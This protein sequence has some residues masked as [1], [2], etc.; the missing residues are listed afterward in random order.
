[1]SALVAIATYSN[2]SELSIARG[3]LEADGIECFVQDELT[4]QVYNF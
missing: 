3:R 1:M 2:I 4:V